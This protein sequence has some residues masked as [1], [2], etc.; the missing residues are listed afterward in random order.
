TGDTRGNQGEPMT[1]A[2]LLLAGLSAA[3]TLSGCDNKPAS[4]GP[5]LPAVTVAQPLQQKITEWDEYTGR[6]EALATVEVR[7]RVSGFIESIHFRDGEIVQKSAL[8]FII[9]QRP[10]QIAVEQAK[11]DLERAR[12]KYDVATSD[13]DRATPL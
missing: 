2:I 3:L 7:A 8:L 11:A 12:A 13:V 4:S 6:F 9:D 5:P 1:R 10:Y